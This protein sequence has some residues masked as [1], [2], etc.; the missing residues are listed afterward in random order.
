[1]KKQT[2]L[3][4]KVFQEK[5][6]KTTFEKKTLNVPIIFSTSRAASITLTLYQTQ[7][8]ESIATEIEDCFELKSFQDAI[9]SNKKCFKKRIN[10]LRL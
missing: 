1:M 6:R 9:A 8:Y 7:Q 10:V 4:R 5:V 3:V 2:V